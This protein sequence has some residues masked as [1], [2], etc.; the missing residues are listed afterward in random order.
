MTVEARVMGQQPKN[1]GSLEKL[2]E[3]RSSFCPTASRRN[4]CFFQNHERIICVALRHCLQ[5]CVRAAKGNE[6]KNN[7]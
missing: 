7:K 3:A 4:I 6:C 2:Q 1:V 5:S